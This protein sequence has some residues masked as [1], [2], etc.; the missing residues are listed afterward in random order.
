MSTQHQHWIA[1]VRAIGPLTHKKMSMAQLR[2]GCE[3]AGLKD[4]RTVLATGNALFSSELPE[5]KINHILNAVILAH[6]L[7]NEVFLRQQRDLVQVLSENPFPES[8]AERP[9]QMLVLFMSEQP[10]S[11]EIAAVENVEGPEQIKVIGREAYID[12]TNGVAGSK[13]TPS[14][15]EK[16][17][18]RSGTARN[19][20]TIEKL[21]D[22]ASS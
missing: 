22:Q 21:V 3:E 14:R 18:G 4:V 10:T 11:S 6:D 8:S 17:L 2:A 12:Y 9:N 5:T 1:L 13:L 19:W 16:L 15:L 20:N 7:Q